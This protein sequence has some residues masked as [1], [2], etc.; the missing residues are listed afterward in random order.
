MPTNPPTA[1][2]GSAE[3]I[4]ALS[5]QLEQIRLRLRELTGGEV[6]AAVSPLGPPSL[7]RE[8]QEQLRASEASKRAVWDSS[9]DGIITMDHEGTITDFNPGAERIFRHLK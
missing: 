5:R 2:R 7:L 3:E 6:E 1:S 8:A 4:G 9:L